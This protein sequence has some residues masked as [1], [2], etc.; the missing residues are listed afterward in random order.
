MIA[1]YLKI[2]SIAVLFYT[3]YKKFKKTWFSHV[4]N[5]IWK[6]LATGLNFF[7]GYVFCT[8]GLE[9]LA[10]S[11]VSVMNKLLATWSGFSS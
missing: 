10:S 6:S 2:C 4:I 9:G 11:S 3:V 8:P 5:N 1:L 7:L